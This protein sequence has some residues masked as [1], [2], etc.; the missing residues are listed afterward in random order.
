M[1]PAWSG[2]AR[3]KGKTRK[4]PADRRSY[5]EGSGRARSRANARD[6]LFRIVDLGLRTGKRDPRCL[7]GDIPATGAHPVRA[8]AHFHPDRMP[9]TVL[10]SVRPITEIVLPA[11]FIRD[12]SRGRVEIVRVANDL[13]SPAAVVGQVAQRDD[14]DAFVVRLPP[15]GPSSA[16]ARRLLGPTRSRP[17]SASGKW[18]WHRHRRA[19]RRRVLRRRRALAVDANRVDEHFALPN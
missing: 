12:A 1:A 16:A 19:R 8:V 15:A 14:V 9:A 6:I 18:K 7:A 11:Q 10:V 17:A 2:R 13:G 4:R 3:K 5:R